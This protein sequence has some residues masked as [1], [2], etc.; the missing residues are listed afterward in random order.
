MHAVFLVLVKL[1]RRLYPKHALK[2][3]WKLLQRS[4]QQKQRNR[5]VK[6]TLSLEVMSSL[7]SLKS[8]NILDRQT[9]IWDR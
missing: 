8:K 5:S 2:D 1:H 9:E 3:K 6:G 7:A 4:T